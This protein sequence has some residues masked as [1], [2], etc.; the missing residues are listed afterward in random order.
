L[1]LLVAAIADI[2]H[3]QGCN[4]CFLLKLFAMFV[5]GRTRDALLIAWHGTLA[6]VCKTTFEAVNAFVVGSVIVTLLKRTVLSDLFRNGGRILAQ[7]FGDI[8]E[9]DIVIKRLLNIY[10]VIHG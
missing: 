8:L 1:R 7:Y 5:A 10:A 6:Y 2:R 9:R 3:L 4:A